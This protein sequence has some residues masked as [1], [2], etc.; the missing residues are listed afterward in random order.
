M[1]HIKH[2]E[3]VACS[4][5]MRQSSFRLKLISGFRT[6]IK[7]PGKQS[8]AFPVNDDIDIPLLNVQ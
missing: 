4:G 8:S 5:R 1:I 3:L 7:G 6:K 2:E